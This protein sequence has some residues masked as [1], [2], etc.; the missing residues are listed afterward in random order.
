MSEPHEAT[1]RAPI[2]YVAIGDSFTEGVGD[3]RPDGSVRGWADLVAQGLA[4]ATGAAVDYANLAI[5]GRLLAPI[6]AEQL[7]PALALQPTVVTFNGG[8]NDMLRPRT[9]IAW[10]AAQTEHALMRIRDSGAEPILLAGANPTAG[11]PGGARVRVKGDELVRAARA[12]AERLDVRFAD[13][14]NDPELAGGQYWSPDRLHLAPVGHRRVAANVLRA[15]G[16]TAPADWELN[17]AAIPRPTRR[18]QLRYTREHVVPWV[19]RRLT[20]RSSG[21]GRTA[22]YAEWTRVEP[23]ALGADPEA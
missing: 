9:N 14:W 23:R 7:E 1:E 15:M 8:G 11:L 3:E 22:K 16:Y 19:Q 6:I 20:G 17:A 10:V 12:I 5:R 4:D 21:D 18:D 13:N 2:R